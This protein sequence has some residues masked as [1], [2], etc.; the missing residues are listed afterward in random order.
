MD[1][2][3]AA[4]LAGGETR[5]WMDVSKLMLHFFS[6][7]DPRCYFLQFPRCCSVIGQY[8]RYPLVCECPRARCWC[9]SYRVHDQPCKT[10]DSLA[11]PLIVRTHLGHIV[12]IYFIISFDMAKYQ[13]LPTSHSKCIFWSIQQ[14]TSQILLAC[15]E[16]SGICRLKS[17]KNLNKR[18]HI[19]HITRIQLQNRYQTLLSGHSRHC[20]KWCLRKSCMPSLASILKWHWPPPKT[21]TTTGFIFQTSS[22]AIVLPKLTF[23]R[24]EVQIWH[25][26]CGKKLHLIDNNEGQATTSHSWVSCKLDPRSAYCSADLFS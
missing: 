12:M 4:C 6:A 7:P 18:Q 17:L 3:S 15:S 14:L 24:N 9:L 25:Q 20:P 19:M 26:C 10:H 11:L 16:A 13:Y 5:P 2:I 21:K 8:H 1:L 23:H 22:W